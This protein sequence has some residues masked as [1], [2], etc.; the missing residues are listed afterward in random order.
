M[1]QKFILIP[2]LALF[3]V[4]I[5]GGGVST[6]AASALPDDLLYP[7]KTE[8]NE[9]I[10][11]ALTLNE[12]D[13][14]AL[15]AELAHQRLFEAETL[16][17]EGKLSTSTA[18]KLAKNFTQHRERAEALSDELEHHGN[19][20]TSAQV[21]AMMSGTFRTYSD[22]LDGLDKK[23]AGN[24]SHALLQDIRHYL[25]NDDATTTAT[26]SLALSEAAKQS[27]ANTIAYA[28]TLIQGTQVALIEKIQKTID[29]ATKDE[30][31]AKTALANGDYKNA[32][33]KAKHAM[34]KATEAKTLIISTGNIQKHHKGDERE[35]DDIINLIPQD[36]TRNAT[37][38]TSAGLNDQT[39][40]KIRHDERKE[41][42]D[43]EFEQEHSKA[44]EQSHETEHRNKQEHGDEF[45]I[46]D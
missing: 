17:A 5:I 3:A 1:N 38:S 37:A 36:V 24:N 18:E 6:A 43:N 39:I 11:A 31:E 10:E 7:I 19:L 13:K 4:V 21:R 28:D 33:E 41:D 9:R 14:A 26:S 16:A 32:Y 27:I 46:D 12:A 29:D 42:H 15:H 45:E 8:V 40:L 25:S 30:T 35:I 34:Q 20:E 22:V 2:T 23:V 44:P